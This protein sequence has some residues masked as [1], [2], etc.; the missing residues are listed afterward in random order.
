[1][2]TLTAYADLD[3]RCRS[4]DCR[5]RGRTSACGGDRQ[6][7]R[8][9]RRGGPARRARLSG[10]RAGAARRARRPRGR[11]S[12]RTASPSTPAPPS[13][14]RRSCSR[15][16]GRFAA[17]GWPTTSTCGPID[18]VLPH[19]LPRRRDASTTRG[20]PARD[21]RR[22]RPLR[23]R[24]RRRLRAL[25]GAPAKPI[26]RVGFEQL[27]RRAVR[28]LD[29]HGP[30]RARPG[31]AR[32]P[33][34]RLSERRRGYVRDERLRTVFSFHPLLVGGNPFSASAIYSLIAFLERRWGVHFAMGGTGRAGA[35]AG[36]P[37][38]GPG[39]HAPLRRRGG[40]D[41]RRATAPRPAC[42]WRRGES[43]RRP[44]SSSPTPTPP[45]PTGT[46]SR[47]RT[48]AA[49]PTAGSS[50]RATP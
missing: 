26:Y 24:R 11:C 45:G 8:R 21:A 43:D 41:H 38:P 33:A 4:R 2:F 32:R 23:A 42:A 6:R 47:R 29:R 27:G 28:A 44:T 5:A 10:D 40:R 9:A 12:A 35:R 46:C 18:A 50:A 31:P 17:G 25:H 22:G 37:D 7:L 36:R 39:R 14:P 19:P 20:D 13:S 48:G 30:R 15:S 16:S 3:T 1:M 49:G 34:Q